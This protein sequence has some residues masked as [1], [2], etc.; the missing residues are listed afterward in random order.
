MRKF[1]PKKVY[2]DYTSTGCHWCGKTATNQNVQGLSVCKNHTEKRMEDIKCACGSWLE[3]R[4]GKYGSYFNCLNCGNMNYDK[5]MKMKDVMSS[6]LSS[7][8]PQIYNH[9]SSYLESD[10]SHGTQEVRTINKNHDRAIS[11]DRKKETTVRSDDPLYF[12]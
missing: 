4:A 8:K 1:K 11:F 3:L 10:K 5:G 9:S 12:S 6:T 7:V 2:G